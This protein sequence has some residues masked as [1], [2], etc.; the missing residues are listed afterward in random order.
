MSFITV[1]VHYVWTTKNRFPYLND[2]IRS[3]VIEHIKENAIKKDIYIDEI[4]GHKEHIHC[5][6]SMGPDKS[7][8]KIAQ[9]LKGESSFWINQ[10]K[11]TAQRFGWQNEYW[12]AGIGKSELNRVRNY[13]K[14][15]QEHHKKVSFEEELEKLLEEF[16]LKPSSF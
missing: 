2:S 1:F 11:L 10:N 13:I 15:Q 7:I 6:V 12:V 5:I 3:Q 8:D 14:K 4:N 9:L 16:G